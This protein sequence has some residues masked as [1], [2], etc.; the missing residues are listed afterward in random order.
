ME[1]AID[2]R[3]LKFNWDKHSSFAL[4]M[5][6]WQV[7]TGQKLF[8]YGQS[9]SGKST[10]LNILSGVISGYSG[11]LKVLGHELNLLSASKR[12][13]FRAN[14]IGMIF[15][16]FNLLPYL[17]GIQNI[18]LGSYF[19]SKDKAKHSDLLAQLCEKL[20]LSAELLGQSASQ[21]SVG[22]QQRIALVRA[23]VNQPKLIIADEP[24]SALDSELR[25][26]FIQLLLDCAQ[27]STVVFVSHDRSLAH[28]FSQQLDLSSLIV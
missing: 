23:L 18:Q 17:S 2:I 25:D 5:P 9:G 7:K 11:Q 8:L 15:Q 21:M 28:H 13:Q 22:Q 27:D 12:D 16:Q 20:Q 6:T 3:E 24:T 19:C 10:L 4:N 1:L 14:N 26:Q